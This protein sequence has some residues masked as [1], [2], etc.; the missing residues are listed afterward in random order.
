MAWTL[1]TVPTLSDGLT[2]TIEPLR[3]PQTQIQAHLR[4]QQRQTQS[5]LKQM[6][7]LNSYQRTKILAHAGK[8]PGELVSVGELCRQ[9]ISCIV[10]DIEVAVLLWIKQM[11]SIEK[12][13]ADTDLELRANSSAPSVV[14]DNPS[15]VP[16][17]PPPRSPFPG[18]NTALADYQLQ[19]MLNEQQN[20]KRLLMA[21]QEQDS[22][23][24][25]LTAPLASSRLPNL[26]PPARMA[27]GFSQF[28]GPT[29]ITTPADIM[30][31]RRA[32]EERSKAETSNT[33]NLTIKIRQSPSCFDRKSR[34]HHHC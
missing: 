31:R 9:Q 5:V 27:P 30:R 33:V 28:G 32:R 18:T 22:N 12:H 6:E 21:R 10:G 3:I 2:C 14:D 11:P 20:K 24:S 15:W 16:P 1:T 23:T 19:L 17:P 29:S 25:G 26:S 8:S 7:R 13:Y 4:D 34:P